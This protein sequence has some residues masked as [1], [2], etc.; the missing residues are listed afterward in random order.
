MQDED[1]GKI[2]CLSTAPN[3][4][5]GENVNNTHKN[6]HGLTYTSISE[7]TPGAEDASKEGKQFYLY[8]HELGK[9]QLRQL[10]TPIKKDLAIIGYSR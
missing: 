2:Y 8:I 10:H 1:K 6:A 5:S 7:V 3:G 4:E 9:L